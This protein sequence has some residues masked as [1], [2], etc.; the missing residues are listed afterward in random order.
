MTL[1]ANDHRIGLIGLGFVGIPVAA[2]LAEAGFDVIGLDVDSRKVE[3]INQG[4]YPIEGDEPELPALLQKVVQEGRLR[5]T[6]H[7]PE[8]LRDRDAV[9]VCVQTPFDV[10]RLEP[11]Y[12]ALRSAVQDIGRHLR[13][14]MLVIIEST[15]APTTMTRLVQ[16][17]LE[18]ES[19]L[20]AGHDFDLVHC[21]ERVMPGKL[22]KNLTTLPRVIGGITPQAAERARAIYSRF[23]QAQLDIAD[24]VTAEVVKTAEN[25][26]RDVQIAFANELAVMCEHLG[27]D[28]Y[29]IRSLVNKSPERNV[30]L[31]G[32]GVG[33]H[34]I[35]KD[36]WLLAYGTKGK[37]TP[38]VMI[39]ARR[40]N[41]RMP[42]HTAAL[43]IEALTDSGV[44][45]TGSRVLLLGAA[46]LHNTDDTRNTPMVPLARALTSRGA[47]VVVHDPLVRGNVDGIPVDNRP[48]AELLS[49]AD[50]AVLVTGHETYRSLSLEK[51][52][53]TMRHPLLIDGRNF[54]SR[55]EAEAAGFYYAGVGK[56]K[57]ND[58]RV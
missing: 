2:R 13:P 20:R 7:Y 57:A 9:I 28:A 53:R 43:T 1:S 42:I 18:E 24:L 56:G 46:Y 58:R 51:M 26:Y 29:A 52:A 17:I 27:V 15:I 21:P 3:A 35:P 23:I 14:G 54:W 49:E 47:A 25:A 19:R 11:R 39:T 55:D 30:H 41:D 36:T 48:W 5:S 31:P 44:P 50:A 22:L 32:V 12:D 8:A 4:R 37:Y 34:C 16:P 6:T 40:L 38:D 10:D 45:V 33:G